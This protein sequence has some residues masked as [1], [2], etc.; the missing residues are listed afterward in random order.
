MI[1][2]AVDNHSHSLGTSWIISTLISFPRNA[3]Q[4]KV[5]VQEIK[6]LS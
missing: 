4:S 1:T 5:D 2:V 3:T 6:Q